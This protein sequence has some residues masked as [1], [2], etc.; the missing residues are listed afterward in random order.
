M[1]ELTIAPKTEGKGRSFRALGLST[2]MANGLWDKSDGGNFERPV[3]AS[4]AASE[5]EIRPFVANLMTG[6]QALKGGN[7]HRKAGYEFLKSIG[8]KV[9]YQRHEEGTVATLYLPDLCALDPGMVDPEGI[10][11]VM[12][13]GKAY[14]AREAA[15]MPVAEIVRYARHLPFVKE[16]NTPVEDWRGHVSADWT[17]PLSVEVLTDM[18]PLSY[19][20]TLFLGNR[21]R[22]P[23]PPDGKF[24]ISLFLTCLKLGLASYP[25][26]SYYARSE[27]GKNA[28]YGFSQN[29]DGGLV[30]GIA[31][32][33]THEEINA[34]LAAECTE[35][36][37]RVAVE[38]RFPDRRG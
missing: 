30:Q 15:R 10:K 33:A 27:F 19:L 21:S 31:F 8:Y 28:R 5:G 18:V 37:K 4:F 20:F 36:F 3:Y 13:P 9:F 23:V 1:E 17:E 22:S 32:Q 38:I 14:L 12:L 6:R 11:F 7:N 24:F 2:V 29:G 34:V 25:G 26:E 16:K 35:Y